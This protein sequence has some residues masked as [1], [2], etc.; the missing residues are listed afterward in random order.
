[1]PLQPSSGPTHRLSDE[2]RKFLRKLPEPRE[3]KLER[4]YERQ[5]TTWVIEKARPESY[6]EVER[7]LQ[8]LMVDPEEE[9]RFDAF[10]ALAN[11][12]RR[13]SKVDG[14]AD[15][16]KIGRKSF[17]SYEP[18]VSH[19]ECMSLKLKGDR[20]SCLAALKI[21]E[22]IWKDEA[23]GQNHAGISHNY[24]ETIALCVQEGYREHDT[25]LLEEG[26]Q[27]AQEA[28]RL[29]RDYAKFHRT[30]GWLY[31]LLG[32]TEEGRSSY[33]EAI[34]RE[35]PAA[36]DYAL[37]L[38]EYR[39]ELDLHNAQMKLS[40]LQLQ[41]ESIAK[42]IDELQARQQ[43]SQTRQVEFLGF[44]TGLLALILGAG[45]ILSQAPPGSEESFGLML[46]L[47][48]LLLFVFGSLGFVLNGVSKLAR[49][50]LPVLLGALLLA[51]GYW[52]VRQHGKADIP[53]R[54]KVQPAAP[55]H[56]TP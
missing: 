28:I 48:G 5:V 52:V 9:L 53:P 25:A 18:L 7:E 32:R 41:A 11:L 14:L 40:E 56:S 43:E 20:K 26:L 55:G 4:A 13:Y 35:S 54:S 30:L 49:S 33:R 2:I 21:A 42:G 27:A 23:E 22:G 15:L 51:A 37:R 47:G 16:I 38:G 36:P 8:E 50:I 6:Q 34:R 31:F 29:D 3:G 17:S 10:F 12:Y 1:M 45:G 39:R 19:L 44:F 24:A 46:T